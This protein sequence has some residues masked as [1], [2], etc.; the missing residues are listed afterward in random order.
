MPLEQ[1]IVQNELNLYQTD[2]VG[3]V[4]SK[5]VCGARAYC[6]GC[7]A[8]VNIAHRNATMTRQ[9]V[10]CRQLLRNIGQQ[11]VPSRCLLDAASECFQVRIPVLQLRHTGQPLLPSASTTG[12]QCNDIQY[13]L[14]LLLNRHFKNESSLKSFT[15]LF[16]VSQRDASPQRCAI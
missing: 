10:S 14:P 7:C 9:I 4:Q 15:H 2:G 11:C 3:K 13:M 6:P 8:S 16:S 12:V 1:C 5:K